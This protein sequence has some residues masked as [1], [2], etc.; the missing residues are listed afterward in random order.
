LGSQPG[1]HSE[2]SGID[3][4]GKN[5][6]MIGSGGQQFAMDQGSEDVAEESGKKSI[7]DKLNPL[8]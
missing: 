4:G 1:I 2:V 8:K 3:Q 5:N 7:V 6:A